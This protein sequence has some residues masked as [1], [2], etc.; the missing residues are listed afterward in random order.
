MPD[1]LTPDFTPEQSP[2]ANAGE[3]QW[4]ADVTLVVA[5]G[6]LKGLIVPV[7]EQRLAYNEALTRLVKMAGIEFVDAPRVVAATDYTEMGPN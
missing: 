6:A 1:E 4:F 2:E 3:M 5:M 7:E